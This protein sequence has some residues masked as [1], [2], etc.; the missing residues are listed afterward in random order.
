MIETIRIDT[1][2][3]QRVALAVALAVLCSSAAAAGVYKWT[4]ADGKVHFTDKPPPDVKAETIKTKTAADP[5]TANRLESFT[6][7]VDENAKSRAE[8]KAAAAEAKVEAEKMAAHCKTVRDEL[9]GL[10]VSTRKQFI[11]DQGELEFVDEA[12]RQKWIKDAQDEIA[13]NCSG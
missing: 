5:H 8:A 13:K 9:G 2:A 4:D 12:L 10:L 1:R 7:Q 11:N 6:K 3:L